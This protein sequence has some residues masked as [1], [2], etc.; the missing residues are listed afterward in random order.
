MYQ[1]RRFEEIKTSPLNESEAAH[2]DHAMPQTMQPRAA[3]EN[4]V[5]LIKNF[6]DRELEV[7]LIL[8]GSG[9]QRVED[10]TRRTPY[11]VTQGSSKPAKK[12]KTIEL[13]NAGD[14]PKNIEDPL[15]VDGLSMSE[16]KREN[17]RKRRRDLTTAFDELAALLL[18]IEEGDSETCKKKRKLP[19]DPGMTRVDLIM[20]TVDR[21][22]QLRQENEQLK[23]SLSQRYN[24]QVCIACFDSHWCIIVQ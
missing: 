14:S 13:S 3:P 18:K 11:Q 22:E 6:N 19:K 23:S 21:M 15:A 5:P 4:P 16:V 2:P 24:K 12:R 7:A 8:V 17:E 9:R 1:R 10:E 20:K